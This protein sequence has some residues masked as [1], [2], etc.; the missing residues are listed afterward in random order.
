MTATT[1][2]AY[3]L[4]LDG[5]KIGHFTIAELICLREAIDKVITQ[6][7]SVEVQRIIDAIC[8]HFGGLERAELFS[9]NNHRFATWPRM[10]AMFLISEIPIYS[11]ARVGALFHRCGSTIRQ[12][13]ARVKE[14][15]EIDPKS[16][17]ELSAIREL[18][19]D[20][21]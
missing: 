5:H 21:E 7:P 8:N 14:L 16:R 13:N 20:A 10:L 15:I 17:K 18:I 9:R 3:R 1:M 11:S 12:D 6:S 19:K 2:T 4:E